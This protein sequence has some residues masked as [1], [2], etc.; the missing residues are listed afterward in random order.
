MFLW[1]DS[2]FLDLF[3]DGYIDIAGE[4]R[5]PFSK[6]ITRD[7]YDGAIKM[8][9]SALS[10]ILVQDSSFLDWKSDVVDPKVI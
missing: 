6:N 2:A 3:L 10:L 1:D 5:E 9:G 8:Y 7:C 4:C